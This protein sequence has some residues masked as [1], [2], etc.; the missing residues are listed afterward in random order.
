M[1][2]SLRVTFQHLLKKLILI[3]IVVIQLFTTTFIVVYQY[4]SYKNVSEQSVELS[5]NLVDN[6]FENAASAIRYL[7]IE[8][9]FQQLLSENDKY[10]DE[11]YATK[12]YSNISS[13]TEL[14]NYL[15]NGQLIL[16]NN[17]VFDL[18]KK[19][20]SFNANSLELINGVKK[21]SVQFHYK[22][23]K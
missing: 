1:S 14:T 10:S 18:N 23:M 2:K 20:I 11:I 12:L 17:K 8:N 3:A 22:K 16:P 15:Q 19:R 6:Y 13:T 7:S 9:K 5:S 4:T 21:N